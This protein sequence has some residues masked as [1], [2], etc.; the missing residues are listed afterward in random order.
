M[1]G[2]EDIESAFDPFPADNRR[3][4][5]LSVQNGDHLLPL[6]V[7]LNLIVSRIQGSGSMCSDLSSI[8]SSP[9]PSRA[10]PMD[11][12]HQRFYIRKKNAS[13]AQESGRI[14]STAARLSNRK[15]SRPIYHPSLMH[16]NKKPFFAISTSLSKSR[17]SCVVHVAGPEVGGIPIL[18]AISNAAFRPFSLAIFLGSEC[19]ENTIRAV[20]GGKAS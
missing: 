5:L 12:G 16:K 1:R 17:L 6:H 14:S 10:D 15:K 9:G 20:R 19:P 4:G 7:R 18:Y 13:E 11:Y 8:H 3:W 2:C